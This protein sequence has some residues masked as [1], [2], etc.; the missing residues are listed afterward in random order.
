[1][2]AATPRAPHFI[3]EGLPP[4]KS[5]GLG[6]GLLPPGGLGGG[7]P[8]ELTRAQGAPRPGGG[9]TRPSEDFPEASGAAATPRAPHFISEGLPPQKSLPVGGGGGGVAAG[10]SG[11]GKSPRTDPGPGG[12]GA[13]G[14]SPKAI[15]GLSRGLRGPH[16]VPCLALHVELQQL[17]FGPRQRTGSFSNHRPWQKEWQAGLT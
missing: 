14:R 10:G 4:Q 15:R 2:G 9:H 13:P 1:M 6:G 17:S 7:N 8:Q 11:R 16:F 12:P 3:S 5:P